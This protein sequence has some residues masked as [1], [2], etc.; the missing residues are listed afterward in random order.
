MLFHCIYLC[1]ENYSAPKEEIPKVVISSTPS[2][3]TETSVSTTTSLQKNM[4]S[5]L[6]PPNADG[7]P[8]ARFLVKNKNLKK[9]IFMRCLMLPAKSNLL[10]KYCS[11][12][13]RK[14]FLML[15][16]KDIFNQK[17]KYIF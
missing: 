16:R 12:Q 15:L 14:H 2:V 11:M 1:K 6:K 4:I 8:I 3:T 13:S 10:E 9:S 17:L 5:T 7:Q